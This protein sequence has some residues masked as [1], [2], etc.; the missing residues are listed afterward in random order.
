MTLLGAYI[1]ISLVFVFGTIVEFGLVLVWREVY[2]QNL[3]EA[4]LKKDKPESIKVLS[5]NMTGHKHA[6]SKVSAL[7]TLTRDLNGKG[8][9]DQ[10]KTI[11]CINI[12]D[13]F[14]NLPMT[15]KV[16]FCIV[17]SHYHS[18]RIH[19]LNILLIFLP[20]VFSF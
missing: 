17:R 6:M 14:E 18:K 2:G 3:N 7:L 8:V 20:L 13:F 10:R 15:R 16:D 1:L 5:G 9:T 4:C 19:Y 11:L 12:Q